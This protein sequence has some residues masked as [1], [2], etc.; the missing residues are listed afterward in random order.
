[1]KSKHQIRLCSVLLLLG[2]KDKGKDGLWA[3]VEN[4]IED[5]K[6]KGDLKI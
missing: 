6:S 1:M 5:G 2:E 3:S 4:M